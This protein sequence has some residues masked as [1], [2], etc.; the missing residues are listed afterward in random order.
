MRLLV[1]YSCPPVT[2][3]S[4][5]AVLQYAIDTEYFQTYRAIVSHD[6]KT[7]PSNFHKERIQNL[8]NFFRILVQLRIT[9]TRRSITNAARHIALNYIQTSEGEIQVEQ[10]HY[11]IRKV[12]QVY[13]V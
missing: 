9:V 1:I 3:K 10:S 2:A 11:A 5:T 8:H 4:V 12:S 6:Y 7:C 13:L